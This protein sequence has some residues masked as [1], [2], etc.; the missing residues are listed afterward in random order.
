MRPEEAWLQPCAETLSK[1]EGLT[2]ADAARAHAVDAKAYFECAAKHKEL[3]E[4]ERKRLG[5]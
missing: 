1:L 2:G 5:E 3:A 4:F